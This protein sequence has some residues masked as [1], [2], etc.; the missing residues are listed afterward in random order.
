MDDNYPIATLWRMV[1]LDNAI[2]CNTLGQ[3]E[4]SK[5]LSRAHGRIRVVVGDE[6][7]RYPDSKCLPVCGHHHAVSKE[8]LGS[9][10][11]TPINTDFHRSTHGRIR[12]VT[13]GE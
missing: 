4:K 10:E 8:H 9:L 11:G 13:R 12:G 2:P 1:D 5:C 3:L 6:A 7:D